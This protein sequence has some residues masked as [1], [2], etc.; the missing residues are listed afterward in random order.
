MPHSKYSPSGFSKWSRCPLS[1]KLEETLPPEG[2]NKY[3][4]WGTLRHAEAE[5][6]LAKDA[7]LPTDPD[8]REVVELYVDYCRGLEGKD[9]RV[10]AK[11][12][13]DHYG[14]PEIYGTTDYVCTVGKALYVVDLKSGLIPV[15]AINN[16][17]LRI[18]ALGAAGAKLLNY[19]SVKMVII[20]PRLPEPIS[21]EILDPLELQ[22][23][24]QNTLRPA[25][26]AANAPHLQANPS[27]KACMW[28][29]AKPICVA[30]SER[31]TALA[32]QTFSDFAPRE[33]T[34]LTPEQLG[35]IVPHLGEIDKYLKAL[36]AHAKS[37]MES[38]GLI[39][40]LKLIQGRRSARK[41]VDEAAARKFLIRKVG[42]EALYD[43]KIKS[44]AKIEAALKGTKHNIDGLTEQSPGSPTMV[45]TSDKR[46]AISSGAEIA[47]K[48]FAN[49]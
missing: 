11:V 46:P 24:C 14:L 7:P 22:A 38:G 4:T 31:V 49:G 2:E 34:T 20:Q 30:Y 9:V 28:C 23:W 8:A 12:N 39:P 44:P 5:A 32:Q 41:W 40:G 48:E 18:Y 42:K 36:K 1:L 10:E 33:L 15:S 21:A 45:P 3:G 27:D 6:T 16:G 29:R 17:Q 26:V 13:L 37:Y 19:R 43:Y 25:F 35:Q 47:F